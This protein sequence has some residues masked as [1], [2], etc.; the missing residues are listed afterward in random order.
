MMIFFYNK[1][2]DIVFRYTVPNVRPYYYSEKKLDFGF[3]LLD[4]IFDH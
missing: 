4:A 3:F 2:K 1:L